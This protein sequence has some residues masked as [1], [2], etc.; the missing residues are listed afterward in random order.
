MNIQIPVPCNASW[1]EMSKT[2]EGRHCSLCEKE[3][4]DFTKMTEDQVKNYFFELSNDKV[5]G[6]FKCEQLDCVEKHY[7]VHLKEKLEKKEA[8][9]FVRISILVLS[10]F[11]VIVG[12]DNPPIMGKV[13]KIEDNSDTGELVTPIIKNDT[14]GF[15]MGEVTEEQFEEMKKSKK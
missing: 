5:C 4:V 15:I 8:N 12:C 7:L 1:L 13:M 3:V 10:F 11:I 6:R 14:T 9:P 2:K